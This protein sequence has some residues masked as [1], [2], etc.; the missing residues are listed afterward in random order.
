MIKI[1]DT[2]KIQIP[3]NFDHFDENKSYDVGDFDWR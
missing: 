1:G 3:A 2:F